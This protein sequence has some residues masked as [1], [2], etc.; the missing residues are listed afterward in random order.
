MRKFEI[1]RWEI[2]KKYEIH[3]Y[4]HDYRFRL[5]E[6]FDTEEEAVNFIRKYYIEHPNRTLYLKKITRARFY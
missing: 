1:P 5:P 2:E 3:F 4:F 6:Y